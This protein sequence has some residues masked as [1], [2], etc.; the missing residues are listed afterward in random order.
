DISGFK[1]S[2]ADAVRHVFAAG[3]IV[4]PF[5]VVVVF[6]GGRPRGSFGN[7]AEA[8]LVFTAS[9]GGLSLNNGGDTITLADPQGH[10]IQQIKFGSAE[11]GASQSI[12]RDPDGN[13]ATFTLHTQVA[14]DTSRLFSPGTR[15]DGVAFA[16]KPSLQSLTPGRVHIGAAVTLVVTGSNFAPG[17]VVLAGNT[18][19]PTTFVSDTRLDAQVSAALLAEAG[20]LTIRVRNPKGE[21][22]TAA[23]LQIFDDP[24]LLT[25][26]SPDKT[27]TGA[28]NL[29]L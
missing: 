23:T 8:H 27:G 6:G 28:E 16:V 22:S 18:P 1:L 14:H 19:L 2:D 24:P 4:P 3:T 21:I 15:A 20:T 7:A 12:N 25:K 5:E 9:S 26:L 17:T 10:V 13:G 29:E 11:G